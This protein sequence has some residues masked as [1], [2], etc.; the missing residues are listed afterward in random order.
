MGEF[1]WEYFDLNDIDCLEEDS[2]D[3]EYYFVDDESHE[4]SSWESY[5]DDIAEEIE[6]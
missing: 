1:E 4:M 3:S 2:E 5:Y 6:Y